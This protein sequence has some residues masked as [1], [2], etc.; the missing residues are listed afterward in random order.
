MGLMWFVRTSLPT[1]HKIAA[2]S[3]RHRTKQE[4]S[5]QFFYMDVLCCM[6]GS[7]RV[8]SLGDFRLVL[9]GYGQ[10]CEEVVQRGFEDDFIRH[11]SH[12]LG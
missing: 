11:V 3:T 8:L 2:P 9:R 7:W 4:E 5:E 1:T 6:T 12:R 10:R